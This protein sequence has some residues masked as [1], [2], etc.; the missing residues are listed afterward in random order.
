MSDDRWERVADLYQ[1]AQE[2]T[3]EERLAFVRQASDGD[4]DLRREVELLLAQDEKT[5][6]I[7]RPIAAA[8]HSL[9]AD[10]AAVQPGSFVG[11][12]RIESLLGVG[13]M[14]EVYR[15]RDTKLN[16]D[17]AIKILPPVFAGDTDRLARFKRE[18]QVLASLNHPNI[19][20]IYGFEDSGAVHAL[21]LELVDGPTL[22]DRIARGALPIDEALKIAKQIGEA[23]EAAHEQG[24]IHRD[25]KPSN[26]KVRDDDTVKVLDFGLAKML[27]PTGVMSPS[28]SMSPT[29]TSPA[30]TQAG[31]ILGTAAYM[32]PEQARGKAIDKRAD[33]WAFGCVVF[34]M[35]SG[36]RAFQA[37]DVSLTL[38][39]V[40][41][42]EPDWA[43]LPTLPPAVRMC[44]RQCLKKD[45]RRRLRDIGD[46]RL[47]LDGTLDLETVGEI[48][49]TKAP[50]AIW[51]W[52]LPI[53]AAAAVAASGITLL[54][55][56]NTAPPLPEVVR[57]QIHAPAGSKIPPGTPA[58]SPDGRT[59][60]YVATS[61]S[62]INQIHLRELSSTESR[63]LPGT[64]DAIHP[65]WSP[66][67]RSLAFASGRVLKRIDLAGGPVRELQAV[68][69]P[70]HGAWNQFGDVLYTGVVGSS[71]IAV[72]RIPAEG[73]SP[74]SVVHPD[75]QAGERSGG[76]PVFLSD[77]RH[78][79]VRM[80]SD[81]SRSGIQLATLDSPE[82]KLVVNDVFS[83][84]LVAP[85]PRGTTYIL[86]AR[87]DGLVAHEFDERAGTVRGTPRVLVDNIGK[88]AS[89]AYMPTVGVSRA[90]T[91]AY[92]AGGD[93]TAATLY[94]V[95]RS[96]ERTDSD[97]L[98]GMNPALSPDGRWVAMTR[99]S[100]RGD[101]E[102]WI[103]DLSRA[104]AS[105]RVSQGPGQIGGAVW[106]PDG[107]RVAYA[108]SGK[109]YV[110]NIDGSADEE[111]LADVIGVPSSW[112]DDGK[113]LVYSFEGKM[114]LWPLAAKGNPIPVGSR[115]GLSRDGHVSPD[116]G[117]IAYGSNESGRDEIYVAPLPPGTG[118][119]PV[120]ATGGTS[121]RWSRK[122]GE[123]F[124]AGADRTMMVVDVHR[125]PTL[126]AGV[127]RK[128]FE[129]GAG[130][131]A[132]NLGFE[133]SA[134]GQRL[135]MSQIGE[136]APDTPITVV[137]NWWVDLVKRPN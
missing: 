59:L 34:E 113:Y 5:I 115:S 122:T 73:G 86:Y 42:S 3:P 95:N 76:F 58:I 48:S 13:G 10:N 124:F 64:E 81:Q 14:G 105:S 121:P 96:G 99:P 2:R 33:I 50:R 69:G 84:P 100:I 94:W 40:M 77:G 117:F 9:L 88:V 26:I 17:V 27:E 52:L 41:K 80:E 101:Q 49:N 118:R 25:L 45:P 135:L 28:V 7:D 120:S 79:L 18:A 55:D 91:I 39:E 134:D 97:A 36:Q 111:L 129:R 24:I 136:N 90:G 72:G 123:L 98:P 1:A 92:Q 85:T 104:G 128:L 61:A 23:L 114:F 89:P 47:A 75:A 65:F 51:R 130:A 20:A 53:T 131:S 106:S 32:A 21:V 37:E 132:F 125:E 133:V 83:A 19:A 87:D 29:I 57:F 16:R 70:W 82:R 31:M 116:G 11:P 127:P 112:S 66:D 93:F 56:R 12:Y 109:I 54:L 110:K 108:R 8:A 44:L 15:A 43:M 102:V 68:T 22:A 30:M 74:V 71:G 35:L 63:V 62:G 78:F 67:G 119:V 137:L 60:A 6:V 38:A 46:A 107:R 103:A 4:S 126:S